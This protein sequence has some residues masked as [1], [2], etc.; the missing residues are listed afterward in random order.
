MLDPI[1]CK[2][3]FKNTRCQTPGMLR[4]RSPVIIITY[5]PCMVFGQIYLYMFGRLQ[6]WRPDCLLTRQIR[7]KISLIL[8]LTQETTRLSNRLRSVL[9]R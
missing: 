5:D 3:F 2:L 7:A 4:G 6:P 9:L 1:P 8:H